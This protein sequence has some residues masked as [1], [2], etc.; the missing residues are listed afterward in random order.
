MPSIVTAARSSAS[1][2]ASFWPVSTRY[3]A[4]QATSSARSRARARRPVIWP[5]RSAGGIASRSS[6]S[7]ISVS[8]DSRVA[9]VAARPRAA[10]AVVTWSNAPSSPATRRPLRRTAATTRSPTCASAWISRLPFQAWPATPITAPLG[11]GSRRRSAR[12]GPVDVLAAPPDR[13]STYCA[14]STSP[15]G[16]RH[17]SPAARKFE[18]SSMQVSPRAARYASTAG[19]SA[20]WPPRW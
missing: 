14:C 13:P 6:E 18:R 11:H 17:A 3:A 9:V 1:A 5:S 12:I 19:R 7:A 8:A 15:S 16:A 4:R 10:R 20:P 2:S